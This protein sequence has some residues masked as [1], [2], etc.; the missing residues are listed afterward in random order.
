VWAHW[1]PGLGGVRMLGHVRLLFAPGPDSPVFDITDL[2]KCGVS[3]AAVGLYSCYV[4]IN[5]RLRASF[6]R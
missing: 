3:G 4:A 5:D 2:F 6:S 1:S